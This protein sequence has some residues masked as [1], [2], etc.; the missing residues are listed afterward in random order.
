MPCAARGIH[1]FGGHFRGGRGE[2]RE[3]AAGVEP[4]RAVFAAKDRSPV[5]I[6]GLYLADGGVAAIGTSDRGAH[7]EAAL[8]EVEPVAHGAAYAVEGNP[9]EQ[10]SVDAALQ[11]QVFDEAAH[12]VLGKHGGD[13]GAQAEAAAQPARHV[14]LAASL[15]HGELARGVDA[16]FAGIETQH[17]FAQ[18]QTIPAALC[19]GND[20]S[21]P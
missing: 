12:G 13:R 5:E 6:A 21:A 10:R 19:V 8:G 3:D 16:A 14:V 18:A 11:D 2:R 7:A 15:P 9:L 17:D 4:A 20:G 1:G